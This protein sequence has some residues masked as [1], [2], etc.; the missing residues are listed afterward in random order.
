MKK[1]YINPQI[2]VVKIATAAMIALSGTLDSTKSITSS[3]D[4]GARDSDFDD[5][6]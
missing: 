1:T 4:F 3:D 2:Q 5:E 6:E